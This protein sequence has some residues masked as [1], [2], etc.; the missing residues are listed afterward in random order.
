[1]KKASSYFGLLDVNIKYIFIVIFRTRLYILNKNRFKISLFPQVFNRITPFVSKISKISERKNKPTDR[2]K[3]FLL[4]WN[5]YDTVLT[6]VGFSQKS[7]LL[8][9]NLLTKIVRLE[10]KIAL[11]NKLLEHVII[12]TKNISKSKKNKKF[13]DIFLYGTIISKMIQNKIRKHSK[14]YNF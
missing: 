6:K 1:M 14:L 11:E 4:K 12:N 5:F 13:V 9:L 10:Q 3:L 2:T 8:Q 7:G